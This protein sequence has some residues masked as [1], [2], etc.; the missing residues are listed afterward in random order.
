MAH[1]FRPGDGLGGY[2]IA[3]LLGS[4]GFAEVYDAVDGAGVHRALKVLTAAASRGASARAGLAREAEALVR[5]E[6][7]NVVRIYEAGVE[8]DHVYLVL[9]M[10]EGVTLGDK[11][12]DPFALA[13]M[14]DV[15]RW[16]HQACEGVAAAHRVGVIHRDLKPANILVTS[17]EVVKVIDF[18][19]AKLKSWTSTGNE[20]LL[21][22]A[23]YM[24][25]EQL[26]ARP[27]DARA[28]VY[29]MGVIL[30]EALSGGHPLGLHGEAPTVFEVFQ[31]HLLGEP[32]PL[33]EVAPEVPADLGELV[34]S[35]LAK[36]PERRVPSMRALADGL[37]CVLREMSRERRAT[38]RRI[39]SLGR[40]SV[41]DLSG[42]ISVEEPSIRPGPLVDEPPPV[43]VAHAYDLAPL[44]RSA[45][46]PPAPREGARSSSPS[47]TVGE[48]RS[49][50]PLRVSEVPAPRISEVPSP[51]ASH[52][53]RVS[54][55]PPISSVRIE[56]TRPTRPSI[57]AIRGSSAMPVV[58]EAARSSWRRSVRR[59]EA[60][61]VRVA[62][63]VLACVLVIAAVVLWRSHAR[64]L[65]PPQPI[66]TGESFLP[67]PAQRA[68][69]PPA[70]AT[71]AAPPR[72]APP[73]DDGGV[74]SSAYRTS[75]RPRP[76][77]A[78]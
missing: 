30:Y 16:I 41:P 8:E 25:P 39:A 76:G 14:E 65:A 12:G 17:A 52:A 34:Q 10:V 57:A 15:V 49:P 21:G 26:H 27:S 1:L 56:S 46:P 78:P 19:V 28:D 4:G 2:R 69:L 54:E 20:S 72:A 40:D 51:R 59:P 6:H 61:L 73:L 64:P 29:S 63:S 43:A 75:P 37:Y 45:F 66:T 67:R 74:T 5:I 24:A 53:P 35:A 13:P 7:V 22:T 9:E 18:G 58:A 68:A 60:T 48:T 36:D 3:R 47:I 55:A 31:Q 71:V 70:V 33:R 11:L 42:P 62:F 50:P 23:L 77:A 44:G 32:R 38:V